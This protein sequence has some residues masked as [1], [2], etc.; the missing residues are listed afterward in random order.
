MFVRK[1]VKDFFVPFLWGVVLSGA[2]FSSC[3]ASTEVEEQEKVPDYYLE[4]GYLDSRVKA[5]NDAIAEC[6]D[7]CETFFWITDMHWEPDLNARKSPG[8]IKYIAQRTGIDKV[9][10]GGDTGDTQAI[11]K[12]GIASLIKAIGSNKVYTVT[13]NH[14]IVDA[15]KYERPFQRVANELRSHNTDIEYGD[16]DGNRSYFYFDNLGTKTRYIG[17]SSFGLYHDE[18]CE[19][20]YTKEQLEWF[21][22]IALNVQ[23]G[24][25]MV[26]FAHSLYCVSCATDIMYYSPAGADDF[27]G[28]ID[29]YKGE[30][31]IACVLLGHTHRDR[32]HI[33]KTGVPYIITA[34]DR[35]S[36][37]NGDINVPRVPG[38]ISEQH[39]EVAVIDKGK[40]VLI[41]FSIGANA[42]DGFDDDPGGEV[43][44]RVISY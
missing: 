18:K 37:S 20:C 42:R 35:Y 14:E 11:C 9:L 29:N 39:F 34:S 32:V 33:G 4:N 26:I 5:I 41:L 19:S 1:V 21:K 24:W 43:D 6:A 36:P 8:L 7:S 25:T 44:I 3:E 38:T 27:M 15:S 16:G 22:N 12:E 2:L 17:L 10:N 23:T 13:G 28:A 40:R 31:V 30:G